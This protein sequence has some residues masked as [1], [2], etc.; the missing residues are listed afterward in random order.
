M[1]SIGQEL[2]QE[3]EKRGIS[4][5][6]ISQATKI[7]CRFLQAIEND[8]YDLL[9]GGFFNK[10]FLRAYLQYLGLEEKPFLNRFEVAI[11]QKISASNL[12]DTDTEKINKTTPWSR[13]L[14]TS[15]ILVAGLGFFFLLLQLKPKPEPVITKALVVEPTKLPVQTVEEEKEKE[16]EPTTSLNLKIDFQQKTWI[17]VYA[18]GLLKLDGIKNPGHTVEITANKE[19][20]IHLGNAGGIIY[21][22]N[23]FKGRS[24]GRSGAVVK[25]IRI[26]LENLKEFIEPESSPKSLN[27]NLSAPSH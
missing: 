16:P 26:T 23:G 25:N 10:A 18:D 21:T 19:F 24:F 13:I 9:P 15:L 2:K 14:F 3:R 6:E 22:L 8:N 7:S 17:Q 11:R 1:A 4:L 5:E 12:K 20:L 27:Q